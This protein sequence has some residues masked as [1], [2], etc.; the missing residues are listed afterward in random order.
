MTGIDLAAQVDHAIDK[1]RRV[2]DAG[3]RLDANDFLHAQDFESELLASHMKA[4]Q[5]HRVVRT[6]ALVEL[7]LVGFVV[8]F[9]F[10]PPVLAN[11][12]PRK[13]GCVAVCGGS[14]RS[15]QLR[16]G[17]FC[18]TAGLDLAQLEI[19]HHL[20]QIEGEPGEVLASLRGFL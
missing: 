4:D 11:A 17:A 8:A 15:R 18:P 19:A 7:G 10:V 9:H 2:G 16:G 20:L 1:T 14:P 13:R 5:L 12:E 3:E 6:L